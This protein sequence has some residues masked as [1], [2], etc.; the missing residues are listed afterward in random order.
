MRKG[1][2]KVTN[3]ITNPDSH[4]RTLSVRNGI[5]IKNEG[6]VPILVICSQLTPLHWGK[7]EPGETWNVGNVLNMG[8]VWFTVSVS[9][10]EERNVPTVTSVVASIVALS[11]SIIL[12]AGSA[13]FIAAA[14]ASGIMSVRGVS[15]TGVYSD[16]K[17]LVVRGA[18]L[19]DGMYALTL[20]NIDDAAPA[21]PPA[22]E[23]HAAAPTVEVFGGAE[24][25]TY[26][27]GGTGAM[28]DAQ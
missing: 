2:G 23:D 25:L 28:H 9:V 14:T 7:V 4:L 19:G 27:E 20:Q 21:D 13:V 12:I 17:T 8:R 10:F 18:L 5:A 24:V 3:E 11:A 15:M 1:L 22:I 16:G 6:A 26:A